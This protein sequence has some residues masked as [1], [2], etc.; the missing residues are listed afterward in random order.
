MS[1]GRLGRVTLLV[2][3]ADGAAQARFSGESHPMPLDLQR[4]PP[5]C[6]AVRHR[7]ARRIE[8]GSLHINLEERLY[9]P[10]LRSVNTKL[11]MPRNV[12]CAIR[13][14]RVVSSGRWLFS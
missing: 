1:P 14:Y 12:I 3:V 9:K 11:T 4:A 7:D 13:P 8:G 10:V 6:R 5:D 2:R